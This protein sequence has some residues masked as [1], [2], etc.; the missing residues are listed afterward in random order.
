MGGYI[1]G[2]ISWVAKYMDQSSAEFG[3]EGLGKSEE[4]ESKESESSCSNYR[5]V[6]Y[7]PFGLRYI[8]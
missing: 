6:Y 8:E 2:P 4:S 1:H 3:T 7:T 5:S